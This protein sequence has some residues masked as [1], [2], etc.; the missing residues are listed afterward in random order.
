M[1]AMRENPNLTFNNEWKG[2]IETA[3]ISLLLIGKFMR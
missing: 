1:V 2:S 3:I